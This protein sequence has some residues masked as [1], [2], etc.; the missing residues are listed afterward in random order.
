LAENVT[1]FSHFSLAMPA[2][3]PFVVVTINN[4]DPTE[5]GSFARGNFA[6]N[7]RWLYV[8]IAT[9]F[10]HGSTIEV[11]LDG[12]AANACRRRGYHGYAKVGNSIATMTA[13]A[14]DDLRANL[15]QNFYIFLAMDQGSSLQAISRMFNNMLQFTC[16]PHV[17]GTAISNFRFVAEITIPAR[18]DDEQAIVLNLQSE[19]NGNIVAHGTHHATQRTVE[20]MLNDFCSVQRVGHHH[21]TTMFVELRNFFFAGNEEQFE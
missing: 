16:P 1:L 17:L 5:R 21:I 2:L 12:M 6:Y 19:L 4:F 13:R 10:L 8:V 11:F 3:A 15:P 18:N 14:L 9:F 20:S 7:A